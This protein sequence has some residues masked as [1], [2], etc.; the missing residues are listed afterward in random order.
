LR[1][2]I[3]C[4]RHYGSW[5]A[6]AR[7]RAKDKCESARA[8]IDRIVR[9]SQ[10]LRGNGTHAKAVFACAAQGFWREYDLPPQLGGTQLLVNRH[11]IS[12]LWPGCWEPSPAWG[13]CLVDRHR[14]RLFDLR[15]G[16]LTERLDFFIRFPVV[17]AAMAS[18]DMM[19]ATPSAAWPTKSASI[20]SLSPRC[21]KNALDKHVFEQWILGC[22]DCTGRSSS[23]NC[24]P[25]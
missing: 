13:S 23:R 14:A 12:N 6:R 8:D 3:W 5:R 25:M 1:P 9:L 7:V 20:S 4:G 11:F 19:E 24:I 10:D 17:A 2:K 18:L 22:Q 15:L 21:L 16:E